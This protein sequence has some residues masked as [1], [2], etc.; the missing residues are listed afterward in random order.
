MAD[1]LADQEALFATKGVQDALQLLENRLK[2]E[3]QKGGLS[4]ADAEPLNH[5]LAP[6]AL[7]RAVPA[8]WDQN[9][10]FNIRALG[11]E[12]R[13]SLDQV[14]RSQEPLSELETLYRYVFRFAVEL[15]LS[16]SGDLGPELA[17]FL[18]F[19]DSSVSRF[20]PRTQEELRWTRQQMAIAIM[21][22]LLNSKPLQN[23]RN[24]GEVASRVERAFDGFEQQLREREE[25]V[26]QLREALDKYK[27]GFNFVGLYQGFE[28]L[29][30]AKR[31]EVT[32]WRKWLVLF[33][34]LGITPLAIELDFVLMHQ[35]KIGELRWFL[36][37]SAVPALS[38]TFLFLYFF[39][40][41][42]RGSDAARA[43]LLQLELRKT[44]CRFI[45][46]YAEYAKEIKEGT[47]A[48]FEN[49]IFAG[50]V[51]TDEKLPATFDGLEQ[52][53][54]LVKAVRGKD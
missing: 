9:C 39:R 21:K 35:D 1:S 25:R 36:L 3:I 12:F 8:E 7:M 2:S 32:K 27:T 23:L 18:R 34:L 31:D 24:V 54:G 10:Q 52:L 40:I 4:G 45:Q 6:I 42:L 22:R 14:A 29:S 43:Q 41:A 47:L 19:T 11:R 48:K 13:E 49:V 16:V 30:A 33:G 53:T 51:A 28:E 26:Q 37:A 46:S 20:S 38:I 44:L 5:L 17:D 15:Q 50:I